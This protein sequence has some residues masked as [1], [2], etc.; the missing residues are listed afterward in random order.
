MAE[1]ASQNVVEFSGNARRSS[2]K[3]IARTTS[4]RATA[5][6]TAPVNGSGMNSPAAEGEYA[7]QRNKAAAISEVTTAGL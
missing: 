1:E 4:N 2:G 7:P 3:A 5:A 6:R